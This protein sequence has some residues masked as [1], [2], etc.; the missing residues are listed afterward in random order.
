M[1]ASIEAIWTP[2]VIPRLGYCDYSCNACGNIC[3]VQAI[4]ALA[5]EEKRQQVMGKATI[6]RDR[7]IPWSEDTGCIVCEEMCPLPEKAIKLEL[8]QKMDASGELIE[9]KLPHVDRKLCIG[10]GIC[11]Y[12][13]PVAGEAAIRVFIQNL[14]QP[15]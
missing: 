10:C 14:E 5:L 1:E 6:D 4:P 2:V 7:C 12:K 13:C 9:V 8:S 3:P 15:I 11:E